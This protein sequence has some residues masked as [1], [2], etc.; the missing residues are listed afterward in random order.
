MTWYRKPWWFGNPPLKHIES[1]WN[2]QLSQDTTL[3]VTE[4]WHDS[5]KVATNDSQ[6]FFFQRPRSWC[7]ANL[8][9]L[10]HVG[11][12]PVM[13]HHGCPLSPPVLTPSHLDIWRHLAWTSLANSAHVDSSAVQQRGF[14][15][16][17]IT[18]CRQLLLSASLGAKRQEGWVQVTGCHRAWE[19]PAWSS[20]HI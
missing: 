20:A 15:H 8:Q 10:L 16:L 3:K 12:V 1:Y 17:W 5:A 19:Q 14:H 2:L 9:V 11:A 13:D 7:A 18:S 6:L 4:N